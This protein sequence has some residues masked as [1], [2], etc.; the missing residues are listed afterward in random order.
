MAKTLHDLWRKAGQRQLQNFLSTLKTYH[1]TSDTPTTRVDE[2]YDIIELPAVT[3]WGEQPERSLWQEIVSQQIQ[4]ANE[5]ENPYETISWTPN[6]LERLLGTILSGF[7]PEGELGPALVNTIKG[8]GMVPGEVARRQQR[9]MPFYSK[10]KE[11]SQL[12]QRELEDVANW[13]ENWFQ[14]D[15]T[16]GR[17]KEMGR[18]PEQVQSMVSSSENLKYKLGMPHGTK[19][20]GFEDLNPRGEDP[21]V[22]GLY[23]PKT[24][25]SH[26]RPYDITG[27]SYYDRLPYLLAKPFFEPVAAHEFMHAVTWDRITD[28]EKK[29]MTE[30][31]YSFDEI[32][33]ERKK[34][35][36]GKGAWA[37]FS[38][39]HSPYMRGGSAT[40][41]AQSSMYYRSPEEIYS[42][43]MG[44]R[45]S[46][47]LLPGQFVKKEL[48]EKVK[49]SPSMNSLLRYMP[50][51]H[52]QKLMNT[53]AV[54]EEDTIEEFVMQ[55]NLRKVGDT[56]LMSAA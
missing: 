52:I 5:P 3:A 39:K 19:W 30:G 55:N 24:K 21:N 27:Q 15:I 32:D 40:D 50:M 45:R 7:N 36:K 25:T 4:R 37:P 18:T 20:P 6:K 31:L 42:R 13:M 43:I 33:E 35:K 56:R 49:K 51:K 8:L 53:L 46:L 22:L 54:K 1:S 41:P 14:S 12:K 9:Q 10:E 34:G 23:D 17:L 44:V 16:K 11:G 47:G 29:I 38:Y 48:L 26:V 28:K 2:P